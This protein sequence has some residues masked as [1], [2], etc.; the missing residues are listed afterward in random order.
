MVNPQSTHKPFLIDV[1]ADVANL[2]DPQTR[3][4]L[5]AKC[6]EFF[7][8]VEDIED[9]SKKI[10]EECDQW[11]EKLGSRWRVN[12]FSMVE[13]RFVLR[14][15]KQW[16]VIGSD[17]KVAE[18]CRR[19]ERVEARRRDPNDPFNVCKQRLRLRWKWGNISDSTA[20]LKPKFV[21]VE[22]QFYLDLLTRDPRHWFPPHAVWW[23]QAD[24]KEE[25][26]NEQDTLLRDSV[27]VV[28]IHDLT[29]LTVPLP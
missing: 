11:A 13:R 9:C 12:G 17:V 26:P 15:P 23:K 10:H 3:A 18:F 19:V 27:L 21:H 2:L 4:L 7:R 22:R 1:A 6:E 14:A 29:F 5:K 16:P 8:R 20:L 24:R 28:L 25:L